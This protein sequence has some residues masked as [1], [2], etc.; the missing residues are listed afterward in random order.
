VT[1]L[2]VDVIGKSPDCRDFAL[3]P[4]IVVTIR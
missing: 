4:R 3:V 2:S 1:L